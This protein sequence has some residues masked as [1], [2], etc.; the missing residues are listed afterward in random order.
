MPTQENLL[1]RRL[2]HRNIVAAM[3]MPDGESLR[4]VLDAGP[5]PIARAIRI[6]HDIATGL[7]HAHL[8]GAVHGSLAVSN[9]IVTRSGVAKITDFGA[10]QSAGPVD[11]RDDVF[12]LGAL[13]YEMLTQRAPGRGSP[14]PP[15]TLN[16]LVPR[17]LDAIVLSMLAPQP[18][19]R[20]PGVP[21]LLRELQRPR[22]RPRPGRRRKCRRRTDGKRPASQTRA[23]RGGRPWRHSSWRRVPGSPDTR[24][25]RVRLSPRADGARL[26]ARA[27]LRI[28]E[29]DLGI[30]SAARH[31]RHRI[32]RLQL[33]LV[34]RRQTGHRRKPRAGNPGGR[35]KPPLCPQSR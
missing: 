4:K 14:P 12:A 28:A 5:L 19:D 6:A 2:K 29:G 8:E 9:I 22:G 3:E 11:H 26:P 1:A 32:R 18:A 27:V 16:P 35:L 21:V 24:S 31:D 15:S 33:L 17:T 34:R 7:A 10:G 25:R 13:F 30:R 20:I 23:P